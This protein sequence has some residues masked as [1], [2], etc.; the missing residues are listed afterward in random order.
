MRGLRPWWSKCRHTFLVLQLGRWLEQQGADRKV[1]LRRD[2]L[3]RRQQYEQEAPRAPASSSGR[4]AEASQVDNALLEEARV[5]VETYHDRPGGPSGWCPCKKYLRYKLRQA[6]GGRQVQCK[7][8]LEPQEHAR[9]LRH[10]GCQQKGVFKMP[11]TFSMW[12]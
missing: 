5:V 2:A 7:S 12:T 11:G 8:W 9:W 4:E 3:L 10:I 6:L 1:Q